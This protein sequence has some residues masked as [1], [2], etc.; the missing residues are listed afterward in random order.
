[1]DQ[2]WVNVPP[3]TKSWSGMKSITAALISFNE[4]N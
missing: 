1:M 4:L 3:V 2:F